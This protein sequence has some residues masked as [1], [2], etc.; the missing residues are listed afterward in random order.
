MTV[1]SE[2]NRV[3]IERSLAGRFPMGIKLT[4]E[5]YD[6]AGVCEGVVVSLRGGAGEE[7]SERKC[8]ELPEPFCGVPSDECWVELASRILKADALAER[9][10]V[11]GHGVSVRIPAR[12]PARNSPSAVATRASEIPLCS[13]TPGLLMRPLLLPVP[14][15][16]MLYPFQKRGV[17]WLAS[18]PA[19]LLADDMGLGKTVQAISAVRTLVQ[20]GA[21]HRALVVVPKALVSNWAAEFCKWAP[22]LLSIAGSP[23]RD[24]AAS[25]WQAAQASSHVLITS[26][27]QLR[28][29]ALSCLSGEKLLVIADEAHR[30]R[31]DDSLLSAA[32]R[33]IRRDRFW[34]MT[35]TPVERDLRDL[36][37]LM[38]I[39]APQRFRVADGL[40]PSL[41]ERS[42]Q[43]VLRRTK[44]EVLPELPR[45]NYRREAVELTPEQQSHYRHLLRA[46]RT[47]SGDALALFTQLRKA[48]DYEPLHQKSSKAAR[49]AELLGEIRDVGEKAIVFSYLRDPLRVLETAIRGQVGYVS[50]DGQ[51]NHE[52]RSQAIEQFKN[53]KGVTALLASMRVTSEGLT[54]TEANHV[55]FFNEWWN[56]S[57][58]QQARDRVNRIGQTRPVFVYTFTTVGTVEDRLAQLLEQKQDLYA[59]VVRALGDEQTAT[60]EA[61]GVIEAMLGGGK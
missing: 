43:Y 56:P 3:V 46:R 23:R 45:V 24:D 42:K 28:S 14:D 39:I 1:S 8:D 9:L 32:M 2:G 4:V 47:K 54:L 49:I 36:A 52:E 21:I 61:M 29:G 37:T 60:P 19:R 33:G 55:L 5:R 18:E 35:G 53:E 38:T 26:Y 50:L 12:S 34:A 40:D 22:E 58:N 48:C 25:F 20:Q 31:N 13:S 30:L 6:A 27:E 44:D 10:L 57:T 51:M 16:S 7:D 41:A 11:A 59:Q 17:A 15:L